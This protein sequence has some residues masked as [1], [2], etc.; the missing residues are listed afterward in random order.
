MMILLVILV[1]GGYA[2]YSM[3]P[4]ERTQL[5]E[6]VVTAAERARKEAVRRRA[7]PEP[8]RDALRERTPWPL[9]MPVL[10]AVNVIVF[11]GMRRMNAKRAFVLS[12]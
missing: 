3:S 8:F 5:K 7:E 2:L 6:R 1:L 12:G 11:L 10:V 9:V 4:D